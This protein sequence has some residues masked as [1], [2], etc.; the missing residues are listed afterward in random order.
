[1][2]QH[3]IHKAMERQDLTRAEAHSA[4][5]AIMSGETTGAQIGAFLVAMRMKGEKSQ[6]ITGFAEAMQAKAGKLSNTLA[7]AYGPYLSDSAI[8]RIP[9]D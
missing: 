1:M 5:N 4:M 9:R 6:E 2:I 3:A 8:H 7:I